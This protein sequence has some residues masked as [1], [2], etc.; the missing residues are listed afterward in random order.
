DAALAFLRRPFPEEFPAF[1]TPFL[2]SRVWER[3][4]ALDIALKFMRDAERTDPSQ[5]VSVL[6]LLDKLG[7]QQ[8]AE[9]YAHHILGDSASTAEELFVAA[10]C[11]VR[12]TQQM[13]FPTPRA[14]WE[15]ILPALRRAWAKALATPPDQSEVPDIGVSIAILLSLAFQQLGRNN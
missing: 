4:G 11:L 3:L 9:A 6:I 10:T 1:V 13:D 2:Q 5:A 15:R 8:E 7:R 12:L 14:I